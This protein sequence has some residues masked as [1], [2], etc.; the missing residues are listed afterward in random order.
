[1]GGELGLRARAHGKE[2]KRQVQE[3]ARRAFGQRS[4]MRAKSAC[5]GSVGIEDVTEK[6]GQAG[7]LV[8]GGGFTKLLVGAL[9]GRGHG[10][11]WGAW[12][13]IYDKRSLLSECKAPSMSKKSMV[14]P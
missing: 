1:M 13:A 14:L 12:R 11:I 7:V 6:E 9:M 4:V 10:L 8:V 2:A 5:E 3:L